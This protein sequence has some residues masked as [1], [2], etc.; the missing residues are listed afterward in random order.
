MVGA[1]AVSGHGGTCEEAMA[2]VYSSIKFLR[3]APQLRALEAGKIAAPV[4][5]RIKPINRCN[6]NCWYCAYRVGN[7][8][9]GQDMRVE[10]RIPTDKMFEIVEDILEMGVR[11]VTFSGGGEPLL[12]KELPEVVRRLK[13][14]GVSV[15][16]LTNGANLRGAMAEAFA[17]HATWVRVSL[18]AWDDDSYVKARGARSGSFTRLLENL[19]AFAASGTSCVLGV[20]FIIGEDN[21]AHIAEACAKL[22][23]AGVHHVKLSG[24]VVSNDVP[25]NNAYHRRLMPVVEAQIAEARRLETNRFA[26]V[27][28][29]H[30]L[31][32]LFVKSYTSCPFLQFLTVIGADSRVYTCQDKAYT[33]SGLL[34]SITDRRFKEF[35]FSNENQERIR[36]LD[37]STVCRHHCVAHNKNLLLHE[38]L[39]TDPAHASFV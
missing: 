13:A 35:W 9:L 10:D 8:A 33:E 37:P 29:Y 5:V 39:S 11:A 26:I 20:S 24:A 15:A 21:H 38:Y 30:E 36:R 23:D 27:D 7:L 31:E 18:D 4:H 1:G 17:T 32:D 19:R 3:F 34:G 12:Y 28:H 22:K 25:A 14:G 16:T 6:H 2:R